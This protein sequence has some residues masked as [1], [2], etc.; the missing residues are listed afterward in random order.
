MKPKKKVLK[1]QLFIFGL[2]TNKTKKKK[3]KDSRYA[4]KRVE[5]IKYATK[6]QLRL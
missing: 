4:K 5:C 3:H 6:R 1:A 2:W